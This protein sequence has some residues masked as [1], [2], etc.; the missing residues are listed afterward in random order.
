MKLYLAP[1]APIKPVRYILIATF[2]RIPSIITS[3]LLGDSIAEGDYLM[4][5]IVF[6]ITALISVIG[7]IV[8]NRFVIERAKK[9]K[10]DEK[11]DEN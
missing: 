7:I 2:A 3:T 11:S 5:V 8:G 1:L 6:V 4:S 10:G 9:H